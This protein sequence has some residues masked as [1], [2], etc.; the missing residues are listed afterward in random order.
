MTASP[1]PAVTAAVVV[2]YHPE[3]DLRE[4]LQ[5]ALRQVARLIVIANDGLSDDRLIGL[6]TA[7]IRYIRE[8]RNRGLAAAL[9]RGL[10]I[11]IQEG[12]TW[13]L[14]LDQDTVIDEDLVAGLGR[15]HAQ[16]PRPDRVAVIAPNYRSS[17]SGKLAH[18]D[19][20]AVQPARV[21]ITSGSMVRL[22]VLAV[23][24]AMKEEFFIEGIDLEFSLRLR[25]AGYE[26]WISG[27]PFM[28]HGA[29]ESAER[30]LGGR[31]V[32]ITHHQVWRY[33]L[34]YRNLTWLVCRYVFHEPRWVGQTIAAMVKKIMLVLLYERQRPA[35]AGAIFRGVF[36][37]ILNRLGR[38][39]SFT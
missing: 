19:N 26:L 38:T 32:L 31:T 8:S 22:A 20:P 2:L 27:R 24:G 9:N 30:R 28:T 13:A 39:L 17:V 18:P 6:A 7:N 21:A 35:K 36:D 1:F 15:L 4:R 29:G 37:G 14:L 34:Q 23:A 16:L 33:Y 3:G 12:M 5:R 25:R 11:A 10:E